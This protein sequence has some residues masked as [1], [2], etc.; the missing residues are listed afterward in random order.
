MSDSP[1]APVAAHWDQWWSSVAL[2]PA[3]EV[4]TWA[5][6]H[7]LLT[8]CRTADDILPHVADDSV[9]VFLLRAAQ[10]GSQLAGGIVV[11]AMI[12]R[13]I[14]LAAR[15]RRATF[16]DYLGEAWLV[17]A[18]FPTARANAVLT[19]LAL[20]TL[21]QVSRQRARTLR[22]V[23]TDAVPDSPATSNDAMPSSAELIDLAVRRGLVR[24]AN[25]APLRAVYQRGLSG[26]EA[27]KELGMSHDML[28]YRCSQAI[29]SMRAASQELVDAC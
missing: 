8:R 11:Q 25:V 24:P 15:D 26:A 17:V 29:K 13:L 23:P 28:R 18:K 22:E 19:N 5:A 27:A 21:K 14:R 9:A 2:S 7:P 10:A 20:D 12:P 6:I 16:D 3:P 1:K 4:A